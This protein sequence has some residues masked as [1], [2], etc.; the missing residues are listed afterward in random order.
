MAT[1]IVAAGDVTGWRRGGGDGGSGYG[2]HRR[3]GGMGE[4]KKIK[5]ERGGGRGEV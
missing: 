5:R 1:P 4:G 2:V 3:K